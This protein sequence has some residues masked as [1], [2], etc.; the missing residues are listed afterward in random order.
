MDI[1]EYPVPSSAKEAP[2]KTSQCRDSSRDGNDRT[3]ISL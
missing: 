2:W 3:I 1:R